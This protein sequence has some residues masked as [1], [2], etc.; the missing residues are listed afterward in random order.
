MANSL[1]A[2]LGGGS[3]VPISVHTY[4]FLYQPVHCPSTP[5]CLSSRPREKCTTRSLESSRITVVES[6]QLGLIQFPLSGVLRPHVWSQISNHHVHV[7]HCAM[8]MVAEW[9]WHGGQLQTAPLQST[10]NGDKLI[11]MTN[12]TATQCKVPG[13]NISCMAAHS[14]QESCT[15]SSLLTGGNRSSGGSAPCS[16]RTIGGMSQM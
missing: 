2:G 14:P 6:C 5:P 3:L 9:R 11:T 10:F 1:R 15:P 8:N 12:E 4:P 7:Q 16:I 13:W